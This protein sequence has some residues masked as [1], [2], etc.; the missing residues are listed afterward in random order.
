MDDI[1]TAVVEQTNFNTARECSAFAVSRQLSLLQTTEWR[2]MQ[3]A[4]NANL[5]KIYRL[6]EL[7]DGYSDLRETFVLTFWALME[8]EQIWS[9]NILWTGELIF[10]CVEHRT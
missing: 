10:T 8:V 3:F 7:K 6:E 4:L 1:T 9:W 5:Y 2:Y